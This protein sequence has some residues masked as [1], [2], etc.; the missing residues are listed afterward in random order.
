MSQ[1]SAAD[2][3]CEALHDFVAQ[4]LLPPLPGWAAQQVFDHHEIDVDGPQG[5]EFA[6]WDTLACLLLQHT[7]IC[8][9]VIE[10]HLGDN[11]A[12]TL[13]SGIFIPRANFFATAHD[14]IRSHSCFAKNLAVANSRYAL[15]PQLVRHVVRDVVPWFDGV[16]DL[17][18]VLRVL[19]GCDGEFEQ[20]AA[21]MLRTQANDPDGLPSLLRQYGQSR[22]TA[23][24]AE[25]RAYCATFGVE[26][27]VP[28]PTAA[29]ASVALQRTAPPT[30]E[31]M[32]H[33]TFGAGTVLQTRDT[34]AGRVV[35]IQ[36]DTGATKDILARFV[37]PLA[38][39]EF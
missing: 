23:W 15:D 25:Y 13:T 24:K 30:V 10:L 28:E 7:E 37:E 32:L 38:E 1:K 2:S 4:Q 17:A 21:A 27:P 33:A 18:A 3:S 19:D 5:W 11:G 31:R 22:A 20:M 6:D 12:V 39:P 8:S 29:V 16:A 14:E 36:F 9:H 35:T 34:S 26:L